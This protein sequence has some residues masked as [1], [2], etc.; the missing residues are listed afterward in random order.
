MTQTKTPLLICPNCEATAFRTLESDETVA[1]R[2]GK[3]S[4]VHGYQKTQCENCEFTF[5]TPKQARAN[6]L[7]F[8]DASRSRDG[9]LVSDEIRAI[10]E[11]FRFRQEDASRVFGGG[12][13]AFSKYE[14]GYVTQSQAMDKLLRVAAHF[15]HVVAYL[16]ALENVPIPVELRPGRVVGIVKAVQR[17]Y[18]PEVSEA[19]ELVRERSRCSIEGVAKRLHERSRSAPVTVGTDRWEQELLTRHG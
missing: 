18:E 11:M 1:D 16:C 10:R 15:P 4:L 9:Y 8:V 13:N 7:K 2:D 6:Q 12:A 17:D 19:A 3:E 14:C 5:V